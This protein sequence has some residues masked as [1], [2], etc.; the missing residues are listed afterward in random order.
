MLAGESLEMKSGSST[1]A[2]AAQELN[3]DAEP[4]K[5]RQL[6]TRLIVTLSFSEKGNLCAEARRTSPQNHS[7]SVIA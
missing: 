4:Q 1:P 3:P 6:Y 2:T 5:P 7:V